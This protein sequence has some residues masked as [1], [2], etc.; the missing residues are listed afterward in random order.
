MVTDMVTRWNSA[1]DMLQ[2]F[3]EQQSAIC[4]ALLSAEVKRPENE[5]CNHGLCLFNVHCLNVYLDTN[6]SRY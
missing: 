1:F 3:L 2:Q 4:A 6:E 5:V